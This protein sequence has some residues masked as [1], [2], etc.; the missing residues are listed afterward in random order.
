MEFSMALVTQG[1][2][3]NFNLALGYFVLRT[4]LYV[5]SLIFPIKL[6]NFVSI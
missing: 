1:S 2:D 5:I 4:F 6:F 3:F